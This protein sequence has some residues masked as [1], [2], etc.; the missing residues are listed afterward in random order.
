ME[1]KEMTMESNE[2]VKVAECGCCGMR[3]ECTADYIA[4]VKERFGGVWVCGL[5]E[6]AIKDEQ[7]RL[8][9]SV[10]AAMLVHSKFRE[11]TNVDPTVRV[12]RSL[13]HLLKKIISSTSTTTTTP[14]S[15]P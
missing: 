11:T 12:A 14:S 6:V 5:C 15:Q 10:E 7:A 1:E 3:E 4:V 8:G 13:L 2:A 9:I